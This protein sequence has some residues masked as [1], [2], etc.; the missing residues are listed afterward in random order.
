MTMKT[1][2]FLCKTINIH[3]YTTNYEIQIHCKWFD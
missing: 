3:W 1:I 2:T